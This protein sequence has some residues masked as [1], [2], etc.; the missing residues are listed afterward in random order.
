MDRSQ[1]DRVIVFGHWAGRARS[2]GR[3]FESPWVM[4]WHLKDGKITRFRAYEDT[5]ALAQA[6]AS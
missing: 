2:T 1:R 5:H 4:D 3:G 6:Y